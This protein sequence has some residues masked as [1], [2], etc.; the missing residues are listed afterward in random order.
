MII[1]SRPTGSGLLHVG[2]GLTG[3][4]SFSLK[5]KKTLILTDASGTPSFEYTGLHAFSADGRELLAFLATDGTTIYW[6]VDD[7]GAV[8]PITIDP[9]VVSASNAKAR[10][11][12]G[13]DSDYF[14]WSV[15]LNSTGAVALVGAYCND[16]AGSNAGAAYIFTMPTG[17]WSGTT[18][19]SAANARFTG[20]AANDNFGNSVALNSTGAMALVGAYY[21]NTAGSSAGAAYIFN[22]PAGG[23]S[24]TTSASAANATFTG[25]AA[26]DEFGTSVALNSTGAVALVGANGN[27]IAGSNAG[28][29][30]IFQPPYVTLTAGGTTTGTAGTI[31]DGLTLNPTG[32]VTNVDLYLGTD[33]ATPTGTAVK[34]GI[35][36]LPDSVA[37]TVDGVN[38]NGKTAG[39]YYLIVY[40]SGTTNLLGATSSAVYTV[41]VP[42]PPV[43]S[44]SGTPT[45]GIAPLTVQFNDT[46]TNT[47]TTWNWNF[48]DGGT[49]TLQNLTHIYNTNG[50]YPV[51]LNATNAAGSNTFTQSNYIT[52]GSGPGDNTIIGFRWNL[53][54]IHI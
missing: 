52:V 17:G 51:F 42:A 50:T 37:T 10:F 31:V 2:F 40:E 7:T 11:T 23:W 29:A 27:D 34:S 19:A 28:A 33:A 9:V 6:V 3:N 38:L 36:S 5:D 41:T 14:G 16:A 46:S 43:A 12:G 49:S 15:A 26:N 54:L 35:S 18:S 45:T 21:N 25:G 39:T 53:S 4:N 44:F 48:G 47:P 1:A 20:G 30:Y 8:Y 24:G 22:M 32:T 13:A